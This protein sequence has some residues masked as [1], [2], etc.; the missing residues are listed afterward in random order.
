MVGTLSP[1]P[2]KAICPMGPLR[3]PG[4]G[5]AICVTLTFPLISPKDVPIKIFYLVHH[6]STLLVA[7]WST[8]QF[9]NC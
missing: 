3:L 2:R 4:R 7:T 9:M 1:R 5:E 8:A 6:L